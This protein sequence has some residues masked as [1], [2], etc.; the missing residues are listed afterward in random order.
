MN[1]LKAEEYVSRN[2]DLLADAFNDF[3]YDDTAIINTLRNPEW[4]DVLIR[5]YMLPACIDKA[6]EIIK[7]NLNR[8][9]KQL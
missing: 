3:G 2:L 9:E 1:T 4:C 7:H 8:M 6:I 5:C